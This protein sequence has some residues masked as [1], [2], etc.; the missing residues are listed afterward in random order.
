MDSNSMR[1]TISASA[2]VLAS[3]K[4]LAASQVTLDLRQLSLLGVDGLG[5]ELDLSISLRNSFFES[6]NALLSD[7]MLSNFRFVPH[8]IISEILFE[9]GNF[10]FD[11][12]LCLGRLVDGLARL[13]QLVLVHLLEGDLELFEFHLQRVDDGLKPLVVGLQKADSFDV[14]GETVVQ[15]LKIALLPLPLGDDRGRVGRHLTDGAG[16]AA[17]AAAQRRHRHA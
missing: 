3:L 12:G 4:S 5:K 10:E 1:A 13:L 7:Q 9:S 15:I 2:P 16:N 14:G 6:G 17:A 8:A 11:L